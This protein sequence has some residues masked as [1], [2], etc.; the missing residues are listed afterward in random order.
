MENNETS[1]IALV[2]NSAFGSL[3]LWSFGRGYQAEKVG[4]LPPLTVFFL[5][6]PLILH[7]P[8]LREIRSTNLPSGLSKLSSKLADQREQLLAVHDRALAM[9]ELTLQSVASGIATSLLHVDYDS[10]L[11]RSN[12]AKPP[13]PP[14]R[15]KFHISSAEKVGRWFARLPQSQVFSLLQVEP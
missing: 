11:V 13:T 12:E 6:L 7:S 2:Q 3:L 15:L 8:T 1:P 5:V 9:R 10:A 14:E 4:D